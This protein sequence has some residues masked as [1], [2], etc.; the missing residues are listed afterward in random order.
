MGRAMVRER[1]LKRLQ[2]VARVLDLAPQVR[3]LGFEHAHSLSHVYAYV[4]GCD[5]AAWR[6]QATRGGKCS[7]CIVTLLRDPQERGLVWR[8]GH[9]ISQV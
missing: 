1:C 9:E 4:I 5:R 3:I 6:Q 2:C 8:G 7:D